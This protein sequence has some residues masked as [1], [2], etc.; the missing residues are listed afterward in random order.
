MNC[1][2]CNVKL[3]GR[4]KLCPNCMKESTE[5]KKQQNILRIKVAYQNRELYWKS[6]SKQEQE[7]LL[8]EYTKNFMRGQKQ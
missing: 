3:T 2:Y 4:N 1:L 7:N 8:L 6:L 5:R